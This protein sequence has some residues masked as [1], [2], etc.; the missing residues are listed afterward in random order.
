[1]NTLDYP[2]T[3]A[4]LELRPFQDSDLEDAF[5]YHSLPEV[6]RYLYW[7]VRNLEETRQA[8]ERKKTNITLTEDGSALCLAVVLKET[9]KVIGEVILFLRSKEHQ[10]AEI[11]FVFHPDYGGRG[12]ATEAAE[13]LLSFG[14]STFGFHRI[15]SRCDAD[16]AASYKLMERLGMRREAHFR[17]N[18]MFKGKW[19]DE[20]VYALL[21]SEW[22]AKTAS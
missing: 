14:F 17:Q 12:Y 22:E 2:L 20:L 10:Q 18:E 8:L 9:G 13:A 19:G 16:N 5:A 11:G 1:M 7:E 21:K 3:T 15:F 4:R 6:V